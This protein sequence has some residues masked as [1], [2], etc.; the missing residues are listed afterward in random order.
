[1]RGGTHEDVSETDGGEI[2][3]IEL[4]SKIRSKEFIYPMDSENMKH[5]SEQ[6]ALAVLTVC[7]KF[8]RSF[9]DI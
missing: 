4:T 3:S 6:L 7:S 9:L 1:M 8:L 2:M 5:Y